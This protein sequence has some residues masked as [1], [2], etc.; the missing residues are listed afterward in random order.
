MGRRIF[1]ATWLTV[2][3]LGGMVQAHSLTYESQAGPLFSMSIPRDWSVRT[4]GNRVVAAPADL[5]MW[6]GAWELE[7]RDDTEAALED[8][9]HY[10]AAWFQ[11]IQTNPAE[12]LRINGM[13]AVRLSG[14]ATH[15]GNQVRFRAVVFEPRPTEICLALGVWDDESQERMGPIEAALGSLRPAL[16][17]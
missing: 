5:S 7:K 16:G 10:L 11:D 15:E 2:I 17:G 1:L 12:K 8:A 3:A 4:P 13:R 9:S 6:L 14:T